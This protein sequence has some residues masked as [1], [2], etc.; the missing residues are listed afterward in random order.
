[1][2]ETLYWDVLET[3]RDLYWDV[4][5]NKTHPKDAV[6]AA[7]ALEKASMFNPH[8]AEPHVLLAQLLMQ[9]GS[10]EAA[11]AHACKALEVGCR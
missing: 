8:V 3:R 10:Y 11:L 7:A 6:D 2:I 9:R 5:M 4:V 1:M